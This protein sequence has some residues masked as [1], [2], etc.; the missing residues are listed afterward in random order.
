MLSVVMVI[1][2]SNFFLLFQRDGPLPVGTL[3]HFY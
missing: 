2:G 3:T 1:L